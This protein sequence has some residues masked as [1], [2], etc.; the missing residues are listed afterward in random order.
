MEIDAVASAIIAMKAAENQGDI[1]MAVAKKTLDFAKT[2]AE[3]VVQMLQK[4][5]G[6]GQNVDV[7][8]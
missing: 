4:A 7:Y 2:E 1:S 5:M 3:L 6:V 8:A